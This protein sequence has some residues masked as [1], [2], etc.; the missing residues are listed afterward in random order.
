MP[1]SGG[2][3]VG[4]AVGEYDRAHKPLPE[5][6]SDVEGFRGL[7]GDA[8]EG[9]PLTNPLEEDVR[10]FLKGLKRSMDDGALVLVWCGHGLPGAKNGL[11]LPEAD[12]GDDQ[13]DGLSAEDVVA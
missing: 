7:L 10:T 11:R 3:F 12:S 9:R 1:V 8:F 2:R 5:A 6:V 13:D 4:I